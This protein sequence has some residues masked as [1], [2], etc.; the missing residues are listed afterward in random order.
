MAKQQLLLLS[1]ETRNQINE[2]KNTLSKQLGDSQASVQ[3]NGT[4]PSLSILIE[5]VAL[6]L[7]R[8]LTVIRN[9]KLKHILPNGP[10]AENNAVHITNTPSTNVTRSATTAPMNTSN[11]NNAITIQQINLHNV[12]KNNR[13]TRSQKRNTSSPNQ[14]ETVIN[15]SAVQLSE[16]ETKLLPRGLSF[17]PTPKRINWTEVQADINEFARRRRLKEYF[18]QNN[19]PSQP[20]AARTNEVPRFRCKGTWSPPS[21]RDAALQ[22][23]I[24]AIEND[25]MSAQPSKIQ[26]NLSKEERTALTNL[27][28]RSDIVI[29]PADK[30]SGT[31]IMDYSWY[32]NECYRQLNDPNY[33][34][35]QST[36]LTNK[37][38][39]RVKEYLNRLHKDDL[40][41]DD[42]FKYLLSNFDP[43]AG[44]LYILPKIHKQGTP[45][46]P[47]ISSNGHPTKRISE[48][49]DYYLKSLVRPLSS[50][51]KDTTHFLLQLEQI[52]PLPDNAIL[53]TID[54]S[55]SYTNIP[56]N[57]G[58]EACRHF[59]S[60]RQ[61]KTLPTER[62]CDL[63][64]MILGMNNFSFNNEHFLQIYGTAMGTRMAPSYA[65]L[66]MGNFEQH[67]I[68]N[69]LFKP[70]IWR[71]FIDD[72]FMVWTEGE[73]N[74]KTFIEYLNSI[75]STIK[76]I[77]EYSVSLHQ[78]LTFLDVQ[79][80]LSNN[81][82]H[83]DLHTKP[84][85]K[86]QYLLKSSC[87]TNHTKKT[88]PFSLLLR[89]RL[90]APPTTSLINA[91]KNL[92]I[93]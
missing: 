75:H 41:D 28:E 85:D 1:E 90:Y 76:F 87:H 26:N 12:H 80:H 23:Y 44:R 46:R 54:V 15:L 20:V 72:I 13:R 84:T 31:V 3:N 34:Q 62:I 16:S 58:I 7:Q 42:T 21:G 38:Q 37:I 70:L 81:Q 59:L 9:E 5:N 40:I 78:S 4:Y 27:R 36:N 6:K 67:A 92:L 19:N 74:L 83:T 43:K 50:Y 8:E 11:R 32:I 30:G 79:V 18:H 82:I 56:H 45:G 10:N 51:I 77:H 22:T 69:A 91:A 65:N 93:I 33:Y 47:I 53:V 35:K 71:R 2:L 60:T 88:I 48:F 17:V 25:I 63:I 55:S 61:D 49:V 57:E 86:H 29:K 14:E 64:R 39:E 73:E 89:I 24:N 66:F 52:G 68:D